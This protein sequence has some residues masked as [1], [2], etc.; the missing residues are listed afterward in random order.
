MHTTFGCPTS[1]FPRYFA[2]TLIVLPV[3][4]YRNFCIARLAR[5]RCRRGAER[6]AIASRVNCQT[7]LWF[8]ATFG[9][10][11][12]SAFAKAQ[13]VTY[14]FTGVVI[15]SF[16]PLV[17]VDESVEGNFT[18]SLHAPD[19]HNDPNNGRYSYWELFD[20]PSQIGM[21]FTVGSSVVDSSGNSRWDVVNGLP[22]TP[23]VEPRCTVGCDLF[24]FRNVHNVTQ[25]SK[26]TFIDLSGNVL[27]SD[28][29]PTVL[30]LDEFSV[31][32]LEGW[33]E[34]GSFLSEIEMLELIEP[35]SGD[36]N[37]DGTIDAADYVWWRKHDGLPTGFDL[38]RANFGASFNAADEPAT[39]STESLL[40]SVPEPSLIVFISSAVLAANIPF[41][42][43]RHRSEI[44][45]AVESP[46][47]T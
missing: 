11:S 6:K 27:D 42:R 3:I 47:F 23:L 13:F 26:L 17:D 25:S 30:D 40:K 43:Y 2:V 15:Q 5:V 22:T 37:A 18:Y 24:Q 44:C 14:R 8:I 12:A 9:A 20:G 10:L 38:W 1:H 19:E 29:S 36:F 35:M 46:A 41:L 7:S 34:G 16:S 4:V 39:P 33:V 21:S 32:E 45:Y 28:D 31:R